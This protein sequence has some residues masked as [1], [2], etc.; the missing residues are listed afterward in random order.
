[1]KDIREE[2]TVT[3]FR[4]TCLGEGKG[5]DGVKFTGRRRV[6]KTRTSASGNVIY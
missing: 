2:K 1:M 3:P 5:E 6:R 4:Y